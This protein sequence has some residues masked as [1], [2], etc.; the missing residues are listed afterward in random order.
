MRR[1]SVPSDLAWPPQAARRAARIF[2]VFVVF[3]ANVTV[4]AKERL[5]SG[6]LASLVRQRPHA[7]VRFVCC[8]ASRRR[9]SWLQRSGTS[10]SDRA[11]LS[12]S[13]ERLGVSVVAIT[14][15]AL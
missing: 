9:G 4:V 11:S 6:H 10:A 14:S 5:R 13:P 3:V 8:V 12:S 1:V 15:R 7:Y 2:V